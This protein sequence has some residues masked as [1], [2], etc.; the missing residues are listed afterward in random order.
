M[1]TP[2]TIV[3]N[4]EAKADKIEFVKAALLKLIEPTRLEE[5]CIQYDLHKDNNNPALFTFIETWATPALLQ[6]HLNSP[7]LKAYVQASEGAVVNFKL[8]ELTNIS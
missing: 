7:H 4:I 1:T 6:A 8:N 5:G 3:A 2:L